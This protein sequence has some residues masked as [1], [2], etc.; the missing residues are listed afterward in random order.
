M[1]KSDVQPIGKG[2]GMEEIKGLVL[3]NEFTDKEQTGKIE[4]MDVTEDYLD[5]IFEL[6]DVSK[7]KPM[8]VVVDTGN[9]INGP[10]CRQLFE[11]LPQIEMYPL[12]FRPDGTFPHHE[13]NPLNYETL[14]DYI[15]YSFTCFFVF[16]PLFRSTS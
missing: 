8:K 3:K 6:A 4:Y 9:G 16:S 15:S 14:N 11:R 1:V 12:Y 10:I 7:I 5:K 2:S 13:A